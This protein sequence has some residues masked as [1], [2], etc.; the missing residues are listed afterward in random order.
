MSLHFDTLSYFQTNQ[1]LP[2]LIKAAFLVEKQQIPIA[3]F[4]WTQLGFKPIVYHTQG[5]HTN[6][7]TVTSGTVH[8]FWFY[9]KYS[10]KN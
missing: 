5:K 1:S 2:L 8:S 7:Y 10:F 3:I 4:G 6:Y 9:N